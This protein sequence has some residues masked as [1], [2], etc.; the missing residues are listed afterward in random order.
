MLVAN[1]L[2]N[3]K[4]QK[5]S[6]RLQAKAIVYIAT[7]IELIESYSRT[8]DDFQLSLHPILVDC[9]N[10]NVTPDVHA[11]TLRR[12]WN[13][14]EGWGELPYAVRDRKVLL[15]KKLKWC[16]NK[17]ISN[18]ELMILKGLVDKKPNI[19]LDELTLEF[20]IKTNIYVHYSSIWRYVTNDLNYSLKFLS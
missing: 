13:M 7:R 18:E 17:K 4:R 16:K 5:H 8:L 9:N 1:A 14:Y 15:D 2:D 10:K 19:Y 20:A 11:D 6:P 12:W 3:W